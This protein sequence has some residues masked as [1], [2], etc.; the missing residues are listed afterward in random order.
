MIKDW[1]PAEATI[2]LGGVMTSI[3]CPSKP[4][5]L[6]L[7]KHLTFD[8][9]FLFIRGASKIKPIKY[10][11][12][13][14][15]N[16]GSTALLLHLAFPEARILA[17]E[18]MTINYDC[19]LH[20]TKD[21]PLIKTLKMGAY[22]KRCQLNLAMPSPEQRPDVLVKHT[23]GG[24][25]SVYGEGGEGEMAAMDRLDNLVDARVDF[26]KIDVEGAEGDVLDGAKRIIA[27]DRP[28]IMMELRPTNM[29]MAGNDIEG[30]QRYIDAAGYRP[31]GNYLGDVLLHPK[32]LKHVG[33]ENNENSYGG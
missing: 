33:W 2:D 25:F 32:E 29:D 1:A 9:N 5:L 27:R 18:P 14:G 11:V 8:E 13:V 23:N 22:S 4:Q 15:A 28:I 3:K 19:L 6:G 7:F 26:L 21:I 12:D 10:I 16:V 30:Y 20:N 24:L 17:I 31:V